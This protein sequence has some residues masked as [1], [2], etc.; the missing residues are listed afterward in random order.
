[1]FLG[2]TREASS[3]GCAARD[4]LSHSHGRFCLNLDSV[5]AFRRAPFAGLVLSSPTNGAEQLPALVTR[6]F[7]PDAA[8]PQQLLALLAGELH[9]PHP[10][11]LGWGQLG[12]KTGPK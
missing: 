7:Y 2:S 9:A 11:A 8:F 6:I 4:F 3:D 5:P 12:A 10:Y 1:V